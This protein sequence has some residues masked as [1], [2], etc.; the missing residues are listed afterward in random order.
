MLARTKR[1]CCK[2]AVLGCALLLDRL[3]IKATRLMQGGAGA[4]GLVGADVEAPGLQYTGE[5]EGE[6]AEAVE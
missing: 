3:V 5:G 1:P 2:L 4:E 6:G